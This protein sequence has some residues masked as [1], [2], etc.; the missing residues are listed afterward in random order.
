[1]RK[2]PV[3]RL[4]VE[5]VTKNKYPFIKGFQE[6]TLTDWDG[7]VASIIFLGGCNLR[8]GFCH[9][10]TLVEKDSTEHEVPF[11]M[12]SEF[13]CKKKGW[14]EGVVI[15]GGE[16]CLHGEMLLDLLACV[17]KLGFL[18]KVDTNGFNPDLL[19][20]IVQCRLAD[21]IAMDIK[22]PLNFADYKNAAGCD[23]DIEKII[24]SK[25]LLLSSNLDY[26][27]RT[28]VVPGVIDRFNIISVADSISGAKK[29]CLQQFVARDTLDPKFLSLKPYNIEELRNM[30]LS[31]YPYIKNVIIRPN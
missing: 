14:I 25:D 12:I 13:L 7:K 10:K 30:A 20:K 17:K 8:C 21:Y 9:S 3:N 19:K 22:A 27:F 23:V 1:M 5:A 24:E 16:P 11:Y 18:I 4:A 15:T 2:P 29:Y 31:I 26:E 6:V 28:T